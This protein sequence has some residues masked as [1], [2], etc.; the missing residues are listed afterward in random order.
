MNERDLTSIQLYEKCSIRSAS[1]IR[2]PG[3]HCFLPSLANRM[4]RISKDEELGKN[5]RNN[6]LKGS[7]VKVN[8]NRTPRILD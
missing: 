5:E 7:W 6:V 1:A 2:S 3:K 4:I 8:L